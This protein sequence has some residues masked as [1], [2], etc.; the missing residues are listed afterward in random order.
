MLLPMC[1]LVD[2]LFSFESD[3]GPRNEEASVQCVSYLMVQTFFVEG[4][5]QGI[6]WTYIQKC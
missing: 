2:S 1:F 6:H 5:S 4:P 3:V